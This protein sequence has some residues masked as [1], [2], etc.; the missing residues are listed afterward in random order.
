MF[1]V[2]EGQ[3]MPTSSHS[4]F[5]SSSY[6]TFVKKTFVP[7]PASWL[8]SSGLDPITVIHIPAMVECGQD[9]F[10]EEST[11]SVLSEGSVDYANLIV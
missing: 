8:E 7:S 5:S 6:M 11:A 4:H 9:T 3:P 2:K 10:S 1:L